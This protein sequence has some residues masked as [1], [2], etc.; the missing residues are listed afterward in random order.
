MVTVR[1]TRGLIGTDAVD[2][3]GEQGCRCTSVTAMGVRGERARETGGRKGGRT[4]DGG[5]EEGT[6]EGS[7]SKSQAPVNASMW[8]MH[9]CA[10]SKRR[11]APGFVVA[12]GGQPG[13][14]V[15]DLPRPARHLVGQ[16]ATCSPRLPWMPRWPPVRWSYSR[17]I[18]AERPYPAAR[19][20]APR[21]R[22]TERPSYCLL[23]LIV[24][25]ITSGIISI[26]L[27]IVLYC[28]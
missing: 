10:W 4:G 3:G 28:T 21:V 18:P 13:L 9:V 12:P 17:P 2:E 24:Y 15:S 25:V 5:S 7:V 20:P 22:A 14:R 23:V 8:H 16:R 27:S 6:G 19:A 1:R 11:A 26:V